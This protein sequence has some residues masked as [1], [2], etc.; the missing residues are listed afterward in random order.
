MLANNG[1]INLSTVKEL[2][3]NKSELTVSDWS[4]YSNGDPQWVHLLRIGH[5]TLKDKG[6][7]KGSEFGLWH[8]TEKGLKIVEQFVLV[9]PENEEDIDA[10]TV[11]DDYEEPPL[12]VQAVVY[13]KIRDT[14]LSK[15]LKE[16]YNHR[17]Q[18]CGHKI[19]LGEKRYYSE[20][21]HL[22][23]LGSPHNGPDII[24]N[25][26]VLCPNHHVEFDSLAIA[27][28]PETNLIEHLDSMNKYIGKDL[29]FNQH[30]IGKKYI[31]YHYD[32]FK[33]YCY[34]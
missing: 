30:N 28:N 34:I 4:K 7:I 1:C 12:T 25:L 32:R 26:I 16:L 33:D 31:Q 20:A 6:L 9:D 5:Q 17:C 14:K 3:S 27:I 24:D 10:L 22:K 23:P 8:F 19:F 21:H 15:K 2:F 18:I 29:F 11:F 13:R